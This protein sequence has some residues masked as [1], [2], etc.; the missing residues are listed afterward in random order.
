VTSVATSQF[1]FGGSIGKTTGGADRLD[2][3][4]T[5]DLFIDPKT[6]KP[7]NPSEKFGTINGD[8]SKHLV[9]DN[10]TSSYP[11]D[12]PAEFYKNYVDKSLPNG[13]N[14]NQWETKPHHIETVTHHTLS[15]KDDVKN[16]RLFTHYNQETDKVEDK[17]F[18]FDKTLG[19]V[20]FQLRELRKQ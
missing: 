19:A 1:N 4:M 8:T 12:M 11:V 15:M 18:Y 3:T 14:K 10:V 2:N 7:F 13:E 16:T 6:N 17:S 5:E 9:Y 20:D